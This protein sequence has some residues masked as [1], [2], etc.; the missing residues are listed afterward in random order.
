MGYS[1]RL[2][3]T[4]PGKTANFLLL[5]D[6]QMSADDEDAQIARAP[7]AAEPHAA[8]AAAACRLER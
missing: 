8:A 1:W 3:G 7:K 2:S 5:I 6:A 4:L